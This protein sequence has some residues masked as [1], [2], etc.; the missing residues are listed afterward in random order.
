MTVKNRCV[1]LQQ[2]QH[3]R[4]HLCCYTQEVVVPCGQVFADA[5]G[6]AVHLY[7]RDCSVQRRH[8]K[9]RHGRDVIT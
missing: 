5:H 9:V 2:Q 8:Q 7:E 1:E 6:N 3:E 4:L